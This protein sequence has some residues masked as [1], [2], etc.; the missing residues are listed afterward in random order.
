M[1]HDYVTEKY[2]KSLEV[3]SIPI[4]MG[5][6]SLGSVIPGSY[7]DVNDFPSIKALAYYLKYLDENNGEYNKYFEWKKNYKLKGKLYEILSCAICKSLRA[8]QNKMERKLFSNSYSHRT[9]DN[10][11]RISELK[12]QIAIS[13]NSKLAA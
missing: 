5:E 8:D 12:R 1:C 4:V 9:C 10:P 7:I 6:N 13:R 11:K 2:W 3:G